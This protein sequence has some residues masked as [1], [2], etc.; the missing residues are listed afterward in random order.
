MTKPILCLDFDGVIHLYTSGW[1]GAGV[2]S[3]TV[4]LMAAHD[5]C[6]GMCGV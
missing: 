6:E 2:Q 3:T 1:K 5:E 4:A